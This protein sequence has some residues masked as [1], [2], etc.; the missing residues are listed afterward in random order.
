MLLYVY[1]NIFCIFILSL[2]IFNVGIPY[3]QT[4][5]DGH[6]RTPTDTDGHRRTPMDTDGRQ[7]NHFSE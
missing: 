1:T 7:F 6:R 2:H 5:T 3:T 4:D